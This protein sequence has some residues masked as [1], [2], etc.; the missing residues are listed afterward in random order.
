MGFTAEDRKQLE[1]V[2]SKVDSLGTFQ[3]VLT[4]AVEII[5]QQAK[6]I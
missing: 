6:H 2:F 5:D 3:T 1:V 4:K